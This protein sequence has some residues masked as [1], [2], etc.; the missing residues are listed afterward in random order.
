MST[1]QAQ[2][3]PRPGT[4]GTTPL[5]PAS[6]RTW[7]EPP[8]AVVRGTVVVLV[9]RGET[10][11]VYERFGRRLAADAYR[12]VAVGEDHPTPHAVAELLAP[13]PAPH[14]VVGTDVGALAAVRVARAGHVDAVVLAGLPTS[15]GVQGLMWQAELDA[16]TACT[17]HQ[18]VLGQAARSSL[19]ADV[20]AIV[21][22]D[23]TRPDDAPLDV[24]VLALHGAADRISPAEQ[25]VA[26]YRTLG[27]RHVA[28]VADGRHDVLNDAAHRSVAA[29]VVQFL[30]RVRQGRDLPVLVDDVAAAPQP[31]GH[32]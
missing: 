7:H 2:P 24:P 26:A 28:L 13:L 1:I 18:R 14:V 27:A 22:L 10:A 16:R 31:V 6:L 19:F 4:R 32:A 15:A 20:T 30:E 8:G 9:G 21:A 12:V 17:S 5:R 23:L 3:L 29:T 11:E 25:A